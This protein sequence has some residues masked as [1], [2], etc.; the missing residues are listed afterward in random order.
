M[1]GAETLYCPHLLSTTHCFSWLFQGHNYLYVLHYTHLPFFQFYLCPFPDP[2]NLYTS[3]LWWLLVQFMFLIAHLI[4]DFVSGLPQPH[5]ACP[6]LVVIGMLIPHVLTNWS[7]ILTYFHLPLVSGICL[8]L[9]NPWRFGPN[10]FFKTLGMSSLAT[11]HY[12][13]EDMA[14]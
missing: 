14:P 3:A 10:N 7:N 9:H 11:Q 2:Y 6:L 4:M 12:N 13:P 1:R 5:L 8:G